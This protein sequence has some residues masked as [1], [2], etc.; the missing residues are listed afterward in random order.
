MKKQ[1]SIMC[2]VAAALALHAEIQMPKIFSDNMVLQEGQTV[3]IWGKADAN[4]KVDVNFAG[5]KKSATAAQD[6]KWVLELSPLKTATSALEMQ[7][8]ENGKEAKTIANVLVGEVWIA[9]GQSNMQWT[10]GLTSTSEEAKA[11]ANYPLF[12]VFT[13]PT[14]ANSLKPE[15]DSPADAKWN[16]VTP[17]NVERFSA[18][19]FYFGEEILK[20]F[21]KPVGIVETP[22]GGSAMVAWLP[23]KD[24]AGAKSFDNHIAEFDKQMATYNYDKA[25]ADWEKQNT[26]YEER[27][28][29]AKA[30]GKPFSERG[31]RKP[32]KNSPYT[33][34]STPEHLFNAKIAPIA[35]YAAKGFIWY[36]GESDSRRAEDGAFVEMFS[37]VINTWRTYWGKPDMPFLFV[38]LTSFTTD[39][40]WAF[41]RWEQYQTTKKLDNVDMAVII[42]IGEEKNIHPKNKI[43]VGK[44][45]ANIAF[46]EVYDLDG[47][48]PYGPMIDEVDYNGSTAKVEFDLD[49]RGLVS[50]GDVRGFEALVGGKWVP[51]SAK[52]SGDEV[53]V[54]VEGK[55]DGVRYLWKS[56]A[57]PDVCLFNK[58]GLPAMP[59]IDIKK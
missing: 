36:Q 42:D 22:L 13:Q 6:G 5:Q 31:P 53:I 41:T 19:G 23:R 10:V 16:V 3:K 39:A 2:A 7:I 46:D 15:W 9:G 57:Q 11:R 45:L 29:S 37:R 1:I 38:Q 30:D 17:E 55:I 24:A 21:N 56:W 40:N 26:A 47:I 49:G 25:L 59:F 12:R 18:V 27:K 34:Q 50:N 32:N 20:K 43:E 4:A 58:D 35:G 14:D 8:S 33:V 44:R 54:S 52:L 48:H 28:A 51:A